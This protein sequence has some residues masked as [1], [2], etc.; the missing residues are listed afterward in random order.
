[1]VNFFRKVFFR[2]ENA[3]NGQKVEFLELIESFSHNFSLNLI[4]NES[5]YDLLCSCAKSIFRKNLVLEMRAKML[6]A[7][8]IAKFLNNYISIAN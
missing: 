2:P 4:C 1:M 7:T 8:Q 3:E 6:S 5:L